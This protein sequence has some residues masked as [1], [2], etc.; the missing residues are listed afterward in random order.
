MH[1]LP[2]KPPD[3]GSSGGTSFFPC[4]PTVKHRSHSLQWKA[5]LGRVASFRSDVPCALLWRSRHSCVIA[6]SA[7][8]EPSVH[9]Q[10]VSQAASIRNYGLRRGGHAI[11]GQRR[12]SMSQFTTGGRFPCLLSGCL[13]SGRAHRRRTFGSHSKRCNTI[14]TLRLSGLLLNDPRSR[15]KSSRRSAILTC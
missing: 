13:L 4:R 3:Y 5:W 14:M 8:F 7:L 12:V 6:V 2:Y 9:A 1:E 10:T 15:G 11:A